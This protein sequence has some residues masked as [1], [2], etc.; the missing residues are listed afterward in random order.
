MLHIY[1][2]HANLPLHPQSTYIP[3]DINYEPQQTPIFTISHHPQY[4]SNSC[5]IT[6]ESSSQVS[7]AP[8]SATE[9]PTSSVP[10]S[11]M[12]AGL[13]EKKRKIA[14]PFYDAPWWRFYEQTNDMSGVMLSGR[15]KVKNIKL[16]TDILSQTV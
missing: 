2:R 3:Q 7:T 10:P 12:E 16:F 13:S 5:E 4:A 15:C 14:N 1:P 9:T 8:S 11:P 6:E